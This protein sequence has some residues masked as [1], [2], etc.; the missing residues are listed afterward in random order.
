MLTLKKWNPPC[1]FWAYFWFLERINDFFY[2]LSTSEY[3][4]CKKFPLRLGN[5]HENAHYL[6]LFFFFFGNVK[7]NSCSPVWIHTW[8][9]T[10]SFWETC[11]K[12]LDSCHIKQ[13]L[14]S[15]G[16]RPLYRRWRTEDSLRMCNNKNQTWQELTGLQ[17][18]CVSQYSPKYGGRRLLFMVFH[19][20]W[21]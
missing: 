5:M 17:W 3:L 2:S 13:S 9:W 7:I 21:N 8:G 1:S 4:N 6:L 20:S 14:Q 16:N 12:I 11:P 15:W 10:K 19:I 18:L